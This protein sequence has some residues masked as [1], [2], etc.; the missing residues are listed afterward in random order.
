MAHADRPIETLLTSDLSNDD[1]LA[2]AELLVTIWPRPGVT[3]EDRAEI[4]RTNRGDTNAPGDV[5][6]RSIL[7]RDGHKVIGHALLFPRTIGTTSGDMTIAALASVCTAPGFR[8]QGLGEALVRSAWQ[9]VDDARLAFS[10]FQT[11]HRASQF[12]L[13]LGCG[14]V[15]NRII[16]STAENPNLNPF[17]DECVM[18]YPVDR[19]GWPHGEIDLRGPG[20]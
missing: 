19:A 18:R 9:A 11:S 8:G 14:F 13:R 15:E 10:L 4:L 2:I 3:V 12:Y 16:D 5:A 1:A 20:Y 17:K 7:F 6:S